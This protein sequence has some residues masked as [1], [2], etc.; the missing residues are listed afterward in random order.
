MGA[1]KNFAE[2]NKVM[3]T[4]FS[5]NG[6]PWEKAQTHKSIR[7]NLLEE[8]YEVAEA[9]DDSDMSALKEELGDLL[10]QVILH[11]RIAEANG[12]FTLDNVMDQLSKK[13]ISR[14]SHIFGQ[15]TAKTPEEALQSWEANKMREKAILTPLENMQ[16]VPKALP[17]LARAQKVIKRS[18]KDSME[19]F[20]VKL[21]VD[22]IN[23]LFAKLNEDTENASKNSSNE[24]EMGTCGNILFLMAQILTK[25]Q[26][27]AEFALTNAVQT[28]INSF[29]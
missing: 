4:L 13:L 7:S 15:D 12:D 20:S 24:D 10:L 9:I 27:N 16:A 11:S 14:H 1:N 6:C 22:E 28:F 19:N 5:E 29:M 2:L 21:A 3:D 18:S 25:K 23:H 8:S 26:I 17:S